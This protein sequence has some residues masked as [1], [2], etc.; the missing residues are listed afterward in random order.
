M[1][2]ASPPLYAAA[3]TIV[4]AEIERMVGELKTDLKRGGGVPMTS[5]LKGIHDSARG[6]RTELD[7]PVDSP[8]GRQL[9][10]IRADIS[11]VLKAEIEIRARPRAAPAA[12]ASGARDRR[13]HGA[14]S[15]RRRRHR[16]A[17]PTARRLPQLRERARRQR[18]DHARPWRAAAISRPAPRRCSKACAAQVRRIVPSGSRRSTPR[19]ASAASCSDRNMPRC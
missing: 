3:V 17:D 7:L 9:A 18:N 5:L 12:A 14:R 16:G 13:R 10:A 11:T 2:P 19:C 8:W 1:P 4:L 6:V 15:E